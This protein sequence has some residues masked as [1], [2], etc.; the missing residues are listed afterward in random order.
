MSTLNGKVDAL[1]NDKTC[2]HDGTTIIL[3]HKL[4]YNIMDK[5][6]IELQK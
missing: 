1:L 2:S 4:V 3:Y 5:L 6:V